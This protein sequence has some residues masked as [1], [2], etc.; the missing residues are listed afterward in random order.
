MKAILVFGLLVLTAYLGSGLLFKKKKVFFPLNYLFLSGLVYVF[1]G[2][3]LG[4][5]GLNILSPEILADLSP[6]VSLGLGWIGFLFGFQLELRYIRKFPRKY[7]SLSVL[8]SFFIVILV[9]GVFIWILSILFP[10]QAYFIIIGM[11]ISLGLLLSLNSPSLLN[12]ASAQI[13]DKGN[14]YYL[15][16]FLVSVSGFWGLAGLVLLSSFGHFPFFETNVFIKGTVFILASIVFPFFLGYLFHFLTLKKTSEQD[17]LVYLLGLVFFTSGAAAYFNLPSLC[18]CM[19]LGATF[20]NLTRLQEK[21]YPLLLSTEKPFYI[22]FLI[23]I[24]AHWDFNF[25]DKIALLVIL[26]LVMRI[27]GY[28]FSFYVFGKILHFPFYLSP[29]FGFCFLSSGGIAIAFVVSIKLIYALPMT[30][31]FVSVALLAIVAGE[32][33]SPWTLRASILRLDAKK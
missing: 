8:Q 32:L 31:V 3:V 10:L 24:G 2:L 26:L 7:I 4:N 29:V 16:R 6:L 5:K 25:D 28:S 21:I 9:C 30:D 13:P 1:L 14:Y 22:I 12:F 23:L 15:A 33:F 19:I 17:L 20:S 18:I 11:A 27:I